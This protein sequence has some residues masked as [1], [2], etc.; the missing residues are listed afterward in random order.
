FFGCNHFKKC[1]E[2]LESNGIKPIDWQI[3]NI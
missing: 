2:F 1:N 3:E